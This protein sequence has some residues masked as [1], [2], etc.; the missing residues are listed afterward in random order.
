[1]NKEEIIQKAIEAGEKLQ[2]IAD[3]E[4]CLIIHPSS[5]EALQSL[6]TYHSD[7]FEVFHR[8]NNGVRFYVSS[9]VPPG[10]VV[11]LTRTEYKEKFLDKKKA[12]NIKTLEEVE[13]F[14]DDFGK[15]VKTK[16]FPPISQDVFGVG[17]YEDGVVEI[18][19]SKDSK[20]P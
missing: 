16:S 10:E 14:E 20:K 12:Y 6:L 2:D 4:K 17:I 15:H 18:F 11:R 19:K 3:K 1:M 13:F 5:F 8:L 9:K 7:G